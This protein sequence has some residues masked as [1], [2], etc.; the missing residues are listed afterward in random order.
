[1][2]AFN[3]QLRGL[4]GDTAQSLP[5]LPQKMAAFYL[6]QHP[7]GQDLNGSSRFRPEFRY[8]NNRFPAAAGFRTPVG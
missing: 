5:V 8:C 3:A 2:P 1:M 4:D 6:Y 7:Y